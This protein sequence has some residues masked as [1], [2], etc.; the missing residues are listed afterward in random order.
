MS[1]EPR[2]L[3]EHFFRHESANLIAVL[4]RAFGF[5]LMDVVEDMVQ[6]S[7]LQA[8]RTWRLKGIPDNPAGWI[9]RV[10]RNRIIDALRR[11]RG[12]DDADQILTQLPSHRQE[13]IRFHP[14]DLN[15]SLL[16]MIIA[17]CHPALER[18]SQL[19]L[20]LKVACGLGD[21][22]IARGLLMKPEAV[23]KRV[24][25]AKRF[26]RLNQVSLELPAADQLASRLDSVHEVLYLLFSEGHSATRGDQ[27]V[28]IDL[29]EE[30]ARLC[31]LLCESEVG[32]PSSYG[33]LALMLFHAAR[34]ESRTDEAGKVILLG[35]QDR[36]CWD[37]DIMRVAEY[38]LVRSASGEVSRYQI[39]AR[40]AQLHCQAASVDQTDWNQI[41]KL[42]DLLEAQFSSPVIRLNRALA[43]GQLG[44]HAAARKQLEQLCQE[45]SL[46]SYPLLY[47]ALADTCQQ[48]GHV[49]K[50]IETWNCA[51]PLISSSHDRELVEQKIRDALAEVTAS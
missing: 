9:H 39:E 43:L 34:L 20:T 36:S 28:S 27:P 44:R 11:E 29:C 23:R 26:L 47:C 41:V 12:V 30:A 17:C 40:I 13:L 16:R 33:L 14:A 42:Y 31:H 24:N 3:V 18:A 22:E 49:S 50:A 45:K 38:W 51:L 6:E 15:D 5:A 1:D 25:R 19:A 35:E 10:A 46:A 4:T 48:L 8:L 2:K 37:Q 21:H 7:M 32:L